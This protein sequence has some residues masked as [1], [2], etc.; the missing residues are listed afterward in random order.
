M[1][2]NACSVRQR[3]RDVCELYAGEVQPT[4]VLCVPAMCVC[5]CVYPQGYG[6][7]KFVFQGV[8]ETICYGPAEVPWQEGEAKLNQIV[9]IG[10][11]LDRKVSCLVCSL[12][13]GCVSVHRGGVWAIVT[14]VRA[15][16]VYAS[17]HLVLQR[18]LRS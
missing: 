2:T 12:I 1:D 13:Y 10:R 15:S 17:V 11:G 5:V 16:R 18:Q 8:H 14:S 3:Q 6:N 7:K 9:F 4:D